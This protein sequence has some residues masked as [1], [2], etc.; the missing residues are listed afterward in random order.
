MLAG[1]RRCC[2]QLGC[3]CTRRSDAFDT[4]KKGGCTGT[5]KP[6]PALLHSSP[7]PA[8]SSSLCPWQWRCHGRGC[9]KPCMRC[10]TRSSCGPN[11]VRFACME[12]AGLSATVGTHADSVP[13]CAPGPRKPK[14]QVCAS[15]Q[16]THASRAWL[17]AAAGAPVETAAGTLVETPQRHQPLWLSTPG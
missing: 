8:P 13:R 10:G 6:V 11:M 1:V 9:S 15:R 14:T 4:A 2:T 12:L 7:C 3:L 17:G 16:Q 5:C